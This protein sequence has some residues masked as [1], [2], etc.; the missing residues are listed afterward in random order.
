MEV[1]LIWLG[2]NIEVASYSQK[3]LIYCI[4]RTMLFGLF[5]SQRRW[6]NGL[7]L[8]FVPFICMLITVPLHF[9]WGTIF[10]NYYELG[11][12]GVAISG[13]IS[14]FLGFSISVIYANI[15]FKDEEYNLK[16]SSIIE[17]ESLMN[18]FELAFPS[19]VMIWLNWWI[20]EVL[21][22]LSGVLE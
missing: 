15:I 10:V 20:W 5:D 16:F 11:I 14:N 7:G 13:A 8:N 4:P 3:Y 18:F 19:A 9:I 6:L 2:Q 22:L 21:I 1:I 17:K 12:A